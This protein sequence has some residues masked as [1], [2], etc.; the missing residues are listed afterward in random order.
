MC[1]S[2]TGSHTH[3][4]PQQVLRMNAHS[5]SSC[6]SPLTM[7]PH[8]II[9]RACCVPWTVH[10]TSRSCSLCA[11]QTHACVQHICRCTLHSYTACQG[12]SADLYTPCSKHLLNNDFGKCYH[13]RP[14]CVN[15]RKL[16][17]SVAEASPKQSG[18]ESA[19]KVA[20][21]RFAETINTP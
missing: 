15:L 5:T 18:F 17:G 8:V 11:L 7:Q 20:G 12:Y 4:H 10:M 19:R 1:H 14:R 9:T 2:L 13:L 6:S 16:G 3:T 21:R